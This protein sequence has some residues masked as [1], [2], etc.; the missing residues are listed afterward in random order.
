MGNTVTNVYA[1]FNYDQMRIAKALGNFRKSDNN[2]KS[3]NNVGSAWGPFLGPKM[4]I[5]HWE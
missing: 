3:K 5:W 2:S 4:N 1:K